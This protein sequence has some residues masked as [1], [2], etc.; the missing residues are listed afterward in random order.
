MSNPSVL[1]H[2]PMP[3]SKGRPKRSD[4]DDVAVKMDRTIVG[5][6]KY[7]ANY[8]GISVAEL[9]SDLVRGPLDKAYGQ[10]MREIEKAEGKG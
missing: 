2:P 9:L 6:A 7:V 5:R 8:R 10:M 4:R 3:A 1:E